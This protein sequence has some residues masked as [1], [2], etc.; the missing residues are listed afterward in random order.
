M[1]SKISKLIE[2]YRFQKLPIEGTLFKNTYTSAQMLKDGPLGTAMIG[3]YSNDPPSSSCFHRLASDEVWH[4]YAGDPFV[5]YLL[6]EDGTLQ[7]VRMGNNPLHGDHVQ[8]TVPSGVWQAGC[9]MEDS[10]YALFGCTMAPGFSSQSFETGITED[11]VKKYPSNADIIQKLSFN[12][13]DPKMPQDFFG[14]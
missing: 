5:L 1:K 9:L 2:H 13:S 7:E 4:F 12:G 14:T 3:L 10:V 11:L 8:F 6:Y